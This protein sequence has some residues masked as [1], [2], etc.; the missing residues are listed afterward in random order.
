VYLVYG[1][2]VALGRVQQ[3]PQALGAVRWDGPFLD[4]Y[5]AQEGVPLSLFALLALGGGEGGHARPPRFGETW[6]WLARAAP[7]SRHRTHPPTG[8]SAL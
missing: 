5:K 7:S 8:T 4:R 2:D 3:L 1:D 6:K